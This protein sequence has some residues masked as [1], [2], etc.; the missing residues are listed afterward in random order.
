MNKEEHPAE[1]ELFCYCCWCDEPIWEDSGGFMWGIKVGD[2]ED[3][4]EGTLFHWPISHVNKMVPAM[5]SAKDSP[6]RKDGWDLVFILCSEFCAD[7]L[8]EAIKKE[9]EYLRRRYLN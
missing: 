9:K 8:Q 1:K 7:S 2:A 5:V 3:L 6:A 4:P